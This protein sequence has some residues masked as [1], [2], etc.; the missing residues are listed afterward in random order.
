M[1][2]KIL[3]VLTVSILIFSNTLI[4]QTLRE[5]IGQMIMI[6]FPAKILDD[7]VKTDLA[8]RNLGGIIYFAANINDPIQIKLL[9]DTI[10]Y[11]AATPP[12]VAV[13]QEGGRVAR[14]NWSNGFDSTYSAYKLGTIFNSE[15]STRAQASKMAGW[16][17]QGGMNLDLAPVVDVNVNPL[18]PAIGKL[19]RSFSSDPLVVA[20]HAGWFIDEFAFRGIATS[21]KHF[22]GHGSA[23]NDSHLGFTDITSTWA[24]SELVPYRQLIENG[25]SDFIMPG[26]LYNAKLDS[27]YPA[28]LSYKTVTNLLRGEL[29][30][31]GLTITDELF[32]QAITQNYGFEESIELAVNA[33]NDI[34]LFRSNMRNGTSLPSQV[35]DI[36]EEKIN[37]GIIPQSRIDESYAR[38]IN[39][40]IKYG[41]ITDVSQLAAANVPSEFYLSQNYPNPFNPTTKIK[42]SIPS[43]AHRERVSEGRVRVLLKI[44]DV[45]GNEIAT[46]VNEE[47]SPGSYEVVFDG[48]GLSSGVYFYRLTTSNFSSTKKLILLR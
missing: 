40:K 45:L 34:L 18:S 5:K 32:M 2:K 38:I 30:F 8:N 3:C 20:K 29:A 46:L 19:E 37:D 42:F 43:L 15:D 21:L 23:V 17:L 16:L 44:Y 35:I 10:K 1:I 27:T 6:G 24:D 11:I 26:H 13:D 28:S 25:Y 22:P 39:L 41:I 48:K 7:S 33:G 14:L 31:N 9:S 47:K 36:I 4:A 12:F